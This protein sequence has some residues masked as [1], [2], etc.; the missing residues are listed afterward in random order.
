MSPA[1]T[2]EAASV[3]GSEA[4]RAEVRQWINEHWS[5]ELT[6]REWWQ[7]LGDSGWGFPGWPREWCGRGLDLIDQ[8]AVQQEFE[9]AGALAAPASGGQRLGA[10]TVLRHGTDEQRARF[11]P[12]LARG[13]E[14]WCQLF[15][16]PDAGSDL[17]S[18]RT[19]AVRDGSNWVINGQKVWT[20]GA[21]ASDRAFLLMRTGTVAERHRGLTYCI[22]DLDQPGVTVLPLKQ[23]T[24]ES[25]FNQVFLENVIVH[26]DDIIGGVGNG[27]EVALTTLGAER[28]AVRS[29]SLHGHH[30]S[31]S[32]YG[33]PGRH[34]ETMD[35]SI[36][37]LR[38]AA[39]A[40]A[41]P[42][43][44]I[45]ESLG[46]LVDVAQRSGG[47]DRSEASGALVELLIRTRIAQHAKKAAEAPGAGSTNGS[48]RK[49]LASR[50]AAAARDAAVV[51]APGAGLGVASDRA[52]SRALEAIILSSPL[53]SIAG[54]TDEIQKNILAE[55]VLGLPRERRAE[56]APAKGAS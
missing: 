56:A 28:H 33:V 13:E 32:P 25:A 21:Q 54:G 53:L 4:V 1:R 43:S 3:Q 35:R 15:S 51:L 8:A 26:E 6:V 16:E 52:L 24:G 44:D 22:V 39:T 46:V 45:E 38:E 19:R 17:G 41:S 7:R 30:W 36:R 27:W 34:S 49:L 23:I 31:L 29:G 47:I 14:A 48:V 18:V 10:P 9:R 37:S 20:S 12:P 40:I 5:D 11:I 50:L 42:R 55:R 2:A